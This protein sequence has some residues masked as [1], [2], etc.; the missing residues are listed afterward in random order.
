MVFSTNQNRQLYVVVSAPVGAI[1][2]LGDVKV[3]ADKDG[4]KFITQKGH[5]G[6][7]RSDLIDPNNIMWATASAPS[8][9]S[10]KLKAYEID[11]VPAGTADPSATGY[12]RKPISGQDYIL[13]VD[14]TQ[15][16]GMSDEDIYQKFGAVHATAA[17]TKNDFFRAM[18]YSLVKNFNRLYHPLVDIAI[19]ASMGAA[20]TITRATKDASGDIVLYYSGGAIAAAPTED[21]K[22]FILE[23]SQAD[24]WALGTKQYTPVYFKAFPTTVTLSDGS[25]VVWGK[26]TDVTASR[27]TQVGNGYMY[28]DLEYFCMGE[29][30]DQ[31]RNVGWPNV[32]P[33]KY[34]ANPTSE[35]YCLDIHY[36]YQGTCEDIQK[37]EKTLTLIST[38]KSYIDKLITDLGISSKVQATAAYNAISDED[39]DFPTP[40]VESQVS[41]LGTAVD[42]LDT[43]V[44]T[45][46]NA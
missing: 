13:K 8:D 18:A 27:A 25:D 7:V 45:L 16:Y 32:I 35:Y 20:K 40:S 29:R 1:S 24:E 9:T 19:G 11:F 37:S 23:K 5:G 46:E 6:L 28:A 22:L 2:N 21:T 34:L 3:G 31:Y 36:A 41:D 15:L 33:T 14:F 10:I 30:A 4:N 38:N 44:T 39:V 26:V 12:N 43:R 42:N 17:M